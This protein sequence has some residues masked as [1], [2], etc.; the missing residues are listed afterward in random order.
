MTA[1]Q[2]AIAK[3]SSSRAGTPNEARTNW[4]TFGGIFCQIE[5]AADN[6]HFATPTPPA[7]L[8]LPFALPCHSLAPI[9]LVIIFMAEATCEKRQAS[10]KLRVE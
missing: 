2:A 3:S 5:R 6:Q 9:W 1:T 7:P 8:L 4:A 10:S